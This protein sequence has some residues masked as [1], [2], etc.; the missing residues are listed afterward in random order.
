MAAERPF[1]GPHSVSAPAP[2][3]MLERLIRL[4]RLWR[5][6][7]SMDFAWMAQDFR[8]FLTCWAADAIAAL[9]TITATLLLSE[10]FDGIGPWTKPQITFML[11]YATLVA[12][13][14]SSVFSYNVLHISRRVGRGQFDHTLLQPQPVW[15]SL[16]T[17]GFSP[18][19]GGSGVLAAGF[20]LLAWAGRDL[21]L[22][23]SPGW[24]AVA[25]LN[26]LASVALIVAFGFLWGSLAFWA[27]RAAE[28][29]SSAAVRLLRELAP[30]PLEPVG[31]A[32][33][34]SLTTFL[35]AGLIA[36]YPS[37]SLFDPGSPAW[38][39]AVTPVAAIVLAAL[40][41][42]AFRKGMKQYERTGSQ[43]YRDFG[44]RR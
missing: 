43:R 35:P 10:R 33:Q 1:H 27:P 2:R 34:Y 11:G 44:H 42:A 3:L 7:A 26:L 5:L 36:W 25:A 16:L 9:A 21:G 30:F 20:G 32:L 14:T 23:A 8:F 40:A 31:T 22:A 4:G 41:A 17:E 18:Y 19:S 29:I 12:G 24:L 38:S 28:E 13:V 15:L 6:Y 37:R 39:K